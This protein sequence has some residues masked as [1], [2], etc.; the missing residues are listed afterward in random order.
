MARGAPDD[1]NIV[2]AGV[3]Y[4]L[5]DMAEL[6]V[7]LGSIVS[8]HRFGD[9]IF[10]DDFSRGL[11]AWEP[12]DDGVGSAVLISD[13]TSMSAGLSVLLSTGA[14]GNPWAEIYHV[15]MAPVLGK[16]GFQMGWRAYEQVDYFEWR[17]THYD[18]LKSHK[19]AVSYNFT[20][21]QL[22]YLDNEEEWQAIPNSVLGYVSSEFFHVGK[23]IVDLETERYVRFYFDNESY[24]LEDLEPFS[25][26]AIISPYLTVT[27]YVDGIA[28][29]AR[30]TYVDNAILT[31][32]EL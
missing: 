20:T 19:F 26:T 24:L 23:L 6:A 32:N 15:E 30:K 11:S 17:I 5:D 14:G 27:V 29:S 16:I 1:S 7:R 3:V 9:V 31:Q 25:D 12:L 18:G 21:K 28:A 10:Q 8:F 22:F 4:R 2:K 13:S